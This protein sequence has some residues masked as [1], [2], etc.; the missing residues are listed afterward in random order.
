MVYY[1]NNI[2]HKIGLVIENGMYTGVYLLYINSRVT[3]A[4]SAVE[5]I[6]Q[7]ILQ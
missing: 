2:T 6:Q 3:V 4:V 1:K 5:L 7:W